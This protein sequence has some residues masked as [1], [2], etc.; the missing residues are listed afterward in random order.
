M[1]Y[2][3]SSFVDQVVVVSGGATGIGAAAV[4]AFCEQGALVACIDRN[5]EQGTALVERLRANGSRVEFFAA[6][7]SVKEQVNAAV[8]KVVATFG[9]PSI[10][11]NHAGT[12][13]VKPFLEL[14]ENDIL[15]MLKVNVVSMFS[16]SQAVIPHMI[17][18]GGGTIVC[19]SSVSGDLATPN[20][21]LY[22]ASKAACTMVAR[23]IAVEFQG[24]NIRCNSVS[25]GMVDTPHG[26]REIQEL[27]ALGVDVSDEMIAQRQGRL[28]TPRDIADVVVF[29]ASS[30]ARFVN[31]ANIVVDNCYSA[32]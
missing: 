24:Q 23:G 17:K 27:R 9:A 15:N 12:A 14:E 3:D 7:V 2:R 18:K 30:Q 5:V 25:P 16:V 13:I 28:A 26:R 10:L 31:G 32:Q 22:C 1:T 6:D 21:I 8:E 4:E 19:T 20:E 11:F 29:A